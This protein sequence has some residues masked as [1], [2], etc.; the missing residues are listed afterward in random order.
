[1][2]RVLAYLLNEGGGIRGQESMSLGFRN[3]T[4]HKNQLY[5]VG[6]KMSLH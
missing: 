2:T 1:M 3:Y 4:L 6:R 5:H